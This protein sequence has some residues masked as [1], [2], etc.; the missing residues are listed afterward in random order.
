MGM[1]PGQRPSSYQPNYAGK[2]QYPGM[3]NVQPPGNT[4]YS[5]TGQ[6]TGTAQATN[7]SQPSGQTNPYNFAGKALY[8]G[9]SS[10]GGS[11]SVQANS[12]LPGGVTGSQGFPQ[13]PNAQGWNG[14]LSGPWNPN[15]GG[16][17][18]RPSEMSNPGM[19]AYGQIAQGSGGGSPKTPS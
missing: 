9:Q 7:F 19:S 17:S 8:P 11:G 4:G 12:G 6:G 13:L 14:L 2:M 10:G 16:F 5:Q 18:P 1:Q 3:P 15:Q